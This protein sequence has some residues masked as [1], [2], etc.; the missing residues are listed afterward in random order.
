[1]FDEM[2]FIWLKYNIKINTVM[3]LTMVVYAA[4]TTISFTPTVLFF[5]SAAARDHQKYEK[6]HVRVSSWSTIS[7]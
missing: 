4:Y 6:C 7:R 2:F 3:I 1:M 5:I